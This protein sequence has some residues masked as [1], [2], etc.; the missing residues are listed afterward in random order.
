MKTVILI[1]SILGA[2]ALILIS[3]IFVFGGESGQELNPPA[4]LIENINKPSSQANAPA[5]PDSGKYQTIT[6][7]KAKVTVDVAP[8]QLGTREEKN[9]FTVNLN[10]HSVELDFDFTEIMILKDDLGNSYKAIEWTGNSGWHH[11]SGDIIFPQ[12]N[13]QAKSIELQLSG[14]N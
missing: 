5:Q 13:Q 7:D 2:G 8:K 6:K 14:I 11:V 9:I 1:L 4:S 10:T 3:A 12:I